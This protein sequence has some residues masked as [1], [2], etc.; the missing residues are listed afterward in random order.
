MRLRGPAAATAPR[1]PSQDR[2]RVGLEVVQVGDQAEQLG[3]VAAGD[4]DVV[5]DD[6]DDQRGPAACDGGQV[7]PVGQELPEAVED[8]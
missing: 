7:R 3:S 4:A 8:L 6:P 1:R 5:L 2:H